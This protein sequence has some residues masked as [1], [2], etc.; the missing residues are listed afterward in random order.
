MIFQ[1]I[2]LSDSDLE[3][4]DADIFLQRYSLLP[5]RAQADLHRFCFDG[6]G[7]KPNILEAQKKE[8]SRQIL[9]RLSPM[10]SCTHWPCRHVHPG[11]R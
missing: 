2:R 9:S 6:S 8:S 4:I 11:T 7:K 1:F 3:Y 10:I 5:S